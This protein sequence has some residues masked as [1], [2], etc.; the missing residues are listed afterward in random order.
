MKKYLILMVALFS[1][2]SCTKQEVY[3]HETTSVITIYLNSQTIIRSAAKSSSPTRSALVSD[4]KA[5]ENTVNSVTIAVFKS[6][7]TLRTLK[8]F[9]SPSKSVTMKVA[10]LTTSDKVVC[11]ANAKVGTFASIKTLDEFN[12]KEVSLDDALTTNGVDIISNNLLMYGSGAIIADKDGYV[13]NVDMYHLNSKV[14][15]NSLTISIPNGGTF[16]A[17]EIFLINVPS[18]LKYSYDNPYSAIG[19]YLH[20][21][22]NS[23]IPNESQKLYL[24]YGNINSAVNKLFFYS[25]PNN[26]VKYTKIVIFGSYDQDGNGPLQAKDTYYPII[27]DKNVLSNKNYVLNV[28]V[29]GPGVDTPTDDLNY[30]N[31]TVTLNVNNFDDISK[32]ISLD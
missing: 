5:V 20:G 3:E 22:L 25:S 2:V 19:T 29:K 9:S 16:K 26:S 17:K 28:T 21:S 1:M 27:I 11:V 8:E 10:N 23:Q 31:L 18:A 4:P 24:G 14:S 30:S 12:A 15:L 32:D 7:G 6:D 13:S